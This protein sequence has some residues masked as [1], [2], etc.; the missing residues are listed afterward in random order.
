M[1][2]LHEASAA[3][4]SHIRTFIELKRKRHSRV[5]LQPYGEGENNTSG[6]IEMTH[7]R[8]LLALTASALAIGATTP[9]LADDTAEATANVD[10]AA[11]PQA[12]D[13]AIQTSNE[14]VVQGSIG[15]RNRS[16]EA[17]PVLVY[18]EEYF[19]RFEPLTAGDALKRVPSVTFLSD[20]IE[21]DGAR[22]RGL[23]P[24][25]TQILI[26]GEKVP[27]SNADRSFFLDRIPAELIQQVEIIRS[28]SARR[29][30]DAVAGTLNIVL[31][32]G[33]SLD[34]GYVRGGALRFDDGEV[35][36]SGGFYYG[37]ALAGGRVLIGA[38]IQ[39]RY[40]PKKKFSLRYGD[41]PENNPNF[42]TDDFDNRE[43]QTDTRDGTDYAFNASWGIESETTEFEI[44]GNFVRTERT[45]DERSFEYNDPTAINGPVRTTV[46]GNL[47]TDNAN[48]NDITQESWSL[49][50]KLS[51]QWSLGKTSLRL[52]YARFTDRQD[53]FEYEVDFDR[54]SPRF[55]GDLTDRDIV[56]KEFSA[57]LEHEFALAEDISLVFGGFLQNKDRD[58]SIAE[59]RSRFNLTAADR[60]GYDQFDRN[61]A[62]FVPTSFPPL[63]PIAG[64]LNTI[65]EDRRDLYALIEG[66]S[67]PL[68]FEAGLR[69]ENT[70]V[71]IDD[72]TVPAT[73]R[74]EYDE[75]LPSASLKWEVGQGRITAS[76]ARTLRRPRFDFISPATLEEELGDNDL[77]GNPDL[78]PETA[79]G[80]D[81]GYEHKIGRTGVVGVNVFYRDIKDLVE[82]ANTG[83]PG[84]AYD[85][86]DDP[87]NPEPVTVFVFQPQNTGDGKVW[88]VEFDL[89]ASLAFIGLPDT[90]VF[91]NL[92]LIDSSIRDFAGKR[93]FNGQSEY[94]YNFGFIQNL[95]SVGAA[96]GATY[97]KQ[98]AAFDRVVAEEVTT[99]YGADLEIF[100]EK[101][102]GNNF[103]IRAVGS[104][105]LN[106][107]KDEV[108]NKFTTVEEQLDREFD[109]YEL[110]TEE[111][112]P[113]FQIMARYAF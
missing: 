81:L 20:V 56:D 108:F 86:G 91:G 75:L 83:E 97:R 52:G 22:L 14:I 73:S 32:D 17:E 67:G 69:W 95:P 72:L 90:G 70:T 105:L 94:V 37:G 65:E 25:Y 1:P 71:R 39:G 24:G 112:G 19:Q 102:F 6:M 110:E 8:V 46:P 29:T 5:T 111:A 4:H 16:E 107:S 84:S 79:W 13:R 58:T 2:D 36:P 34:G 21:S 50:G 53:E 49:T 96:F 61:P 99:T 38:N 77:L 12:Q 33:Y 10:T 45:E 26:N 54:S 43:D 47:L 40:N 28:S 48:V 74:T 15:F 3:L 23:D 100:V 44:S 60:E 80:G 27:G 92:G 82:I 85:P 35:K 9:A 78:A 88:G 64:G 66:K 109:E 76:V 30:G 59:I 63:E 68:T 42:A 7:T 104:N 103:T 57:N 62:E 31:R 101:R 89:S 18:D 51:Q 87:D 41:S 11:D 93:R 98:G 113:V 55:T 106:G